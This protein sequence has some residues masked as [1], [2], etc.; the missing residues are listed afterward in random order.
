[1]PMWRP[2]AIFARMDRHDGSVVYIVDD[3][4][5]LR[6]S[7]RNLLRSVGFRVEMFES[8]EAFLEANH[9]LATGCLV[10]DLRMPGMGGFLAPSAIVAP[11]LLFDEIEF[12]LPQDQLPKLPVVPPPNAAR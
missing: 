12:E 11:A 8:A 9:R 5:S 4:A 6:R 3:D 7:L 1:M 2:P 10:L